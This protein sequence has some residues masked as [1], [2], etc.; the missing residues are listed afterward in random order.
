MR[1]T[2]S[3]LSPHSLHLLFSN[4]LSFLFWIV[5]MS[6]FCIII[7]TT[8]TTTSLYYFLVN[9]INI[10]N[11]SL[12]LLLLSCFFFWTDLPIT[13]RQTLQYAI[14][15]GYSNVY[16]SWNA[17]FP[18]LQLSTNECARA[19]SRPLRDATSAK[20]KQ[21]KVFGETEAFSFSIWFFECSYNETNSLTM[22][23]EVAVAAAAAA[24]TAWLLRYES[25]K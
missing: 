8:T 18:Q 10:D 4:V 24:A 16:W 14:S 7:L 11:I 23:S 6:L 25:N 5:L 22:I 13:M 17:R 21:I 20:V 15:V 19:L 12:R 9:L 1:S 2:V 3:S